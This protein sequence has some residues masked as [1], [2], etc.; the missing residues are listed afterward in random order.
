MQIDVFTDGSATIA[1]NPG[2]Y[3][4]VI[5]SNKVIVKSGSGHLPSATNNDAELEAAIKGLE[6]AFQFTTEL[7]LLIN[8]TMTLV[9]DSRLVLG[10]TS[11]E[12][13]FKQLN[14][15]HKYEELMT[16]VKRMGVNTRWIRGHS[17]DLYNE[18][19]DKLANA[20][21]LQKSMELEKES[22]KESGNTLIGT[23]KNG[24]VCL[25]YRDQLKIMDMENNIIENYD[26]EI[27]GQRGS[28][29]E[30]REEKNR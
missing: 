15:M 10:W 6:A 7:P 22:A 5:V 9:S 8:Y 29:L 4:Y 24:I 1:G 2:G 27:H 3:G 23:K 14:K 25:W 28:L 30:V 13:Q 18:M 26:R 16:L 11:G 19:C 20:A 12:Y 17:G 21:R